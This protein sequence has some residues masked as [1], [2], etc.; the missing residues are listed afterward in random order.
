MH[1]F[2]KKIHTHTYVC[3]HVYNL[4]FK[5]TLGSNFISL[6]SHKEKVKYK[7]IKKLGMA[8]Q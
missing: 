1:C 4:I 7:K 3:V 6:T 8:M 5:T 2:K